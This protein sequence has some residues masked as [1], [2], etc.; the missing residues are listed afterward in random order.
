MSRPEHLASERLQKL[1]S[2]QARGAQPYPYAFQRTHTSEAVR[3][4]E[5]ALAGTTVALAGRRHQR[6]L[7]RVARHRRVED[8]VVGLLLPLR[9]DGE[10]N[11]SLLDVHARDRACAAAIAVRCIFEIAA[12]N[13]SPYDRP[14]LK[15][16][17]SR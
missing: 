4:A 14:C 5:A 17:S 2:W 13:V 16:R 12:R 1:A 3:A 6:P 8:E 10:V 11:R 15:F 9:R 7:Q